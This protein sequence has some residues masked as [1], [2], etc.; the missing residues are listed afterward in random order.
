MARLAVAGILVALT[1]TPGAAMSQ[2]D[3]RVGAPP[4]PTTT[5]PA[6]PVVR[7][8]PPM[9]PRNVP[10]VVMQGQS[11]QSAANAYRP[12]HYGFRLPPQWLS[13]PYFIPNYSLYRLPRPAAGFGWSRYYND[14]VLTDSY[15]RVYDWRSDLD[16]SRDTRWAAEDYSDSYGYRDDPRHDAPRPRRNDG[17]AGAVIGGVVG[18]IAGNVIGGDGNRLA[19]TLIGG[20]VGALAGQAIDKSASRRRAERDGDYRDWG[21]SDRGFA[22]SRPHWRYVER[23]YGYGYGWMEGP[24]VTTTTVTQG[25]PVMTKTV[26]YVTEYVTVPAGRTKYVKRAKYVPRCGC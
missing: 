24:T 7:P 9:P 18:G 25:A 8:L 21:Y 10:P 1:L 17:I 16:W 3:S 15:G 12:P 26:R 19:G 11:V 2:S 13:A 4:M 14:A 6:P 20:G 5:M 23:G 22:P